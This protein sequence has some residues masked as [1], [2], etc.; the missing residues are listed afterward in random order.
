ML[1]AQ[2]LKQKYLKDLMTA[3][4]GD[5]DTRKKRRLKI[6]PQM[7]RTVILYTCADDQRGQS[8]ARLLTQYMK[9]Y[10]GDEQS[11][12]ELSIEMQKRYLYVMFQQTLDIF[13]PLYV[14]STAEE[15]K[16]LVESGGWRR[17]KQKTPGISRIS[18]SNTNHQVDLY[19]QDPLDMHKCE[20]DVIYDCYRR[21]ISLMLKA[22]EN[23]SWPIH[24]IRS[25][26][27]SHM[28]EILQQINNRFIV[29]P[30]APYKKKFDKKI[31]LYDVGNR[32]IKMQKV[33]AQFGRRK[34]VVFQ[35]IDDQIH[36]VSPPS[37]GDKVENPPSSRNESN[38][39]SFFLPLPE[40]NFEYGDHC[41]FT[42]MKY[43][44][45]NGDFNH[46]FRNCE[47][48][49]GDTKSQFSKLQKQGGEGDTNLARDR[50]R[51]SSG[52][53]DEYAFRTRLHSSFSGDSFGGT[54]SMP[55]STEENSPSLYN[56]ILRYP[57]AQHNKKTFGE[58]LKACDISMNPSFTPSSVS[59]NGDLNPI[60]ESIDDAIE[61]LVDVHIGDNDEDTNTDVD[62]A[63][64]MPNPPSQTRSER[65]RSSMLQHSMS[66]SQNHITSKWRNNDYK[67][68]ASAGLLS[69]KNVVYCGTQNE[70]DFFRSSSMLRLCALGNDATVHRILC[71]FVVTMQEFH[72]QLSQLNVR[73]Y[74]A[75]TSKRNNILATYVASR[76]AWYRRHIYV[77]LSSPSFCFPYVNEQ[78]V[79]RYSV[80]ETIDWVRTQVVESK[81]TA[82]KYWR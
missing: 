38:I 51:S 21:A 53:V 8:L 20:D 25:W 4:D 39:L 32:I 13:D 80:D 49:Q 44:M 61:A 31:S 46:I 17:L 26:L 58:F 5:G 27:S 37:S 66:R 7:Q 52:D 79:Y 28:A 75:P 67:R 12:K 30:H 18:T 40:M 47:M 36:P 15:K 29:F 10:V 34:S 63:Y 1:S 2:G 22:E 64:I 78:N 73:V 23:D 43:P 50:A 76:D 70:I 77:P 42:E 19:V 62:Q 9:M 72:L 11:E 56:G 57:E 55:T 41:N 14:P 60:G 45:W 65:T 24:A 3:S 81:E 33:A 59:A 69:E 6:W 35:N 48:N 71:N 54:D 68:I 16:I 82:L 74:I